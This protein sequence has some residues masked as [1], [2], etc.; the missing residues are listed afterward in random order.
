MEKNLQLYVK[1]VAIWLKEIKIGICQWRKGKLNDFRNEIE[2]VLT[3][4]I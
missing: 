2:K 1:S 4:L 3:I